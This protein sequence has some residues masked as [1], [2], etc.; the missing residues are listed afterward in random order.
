[1]TRDIGLAPFLIMG[2]NQVRTI[3]LEL[4]GLSIAVEKTYLASL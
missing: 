4:I 1:M 2:Y 3:R